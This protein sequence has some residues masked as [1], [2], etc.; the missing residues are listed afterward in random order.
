M[1][2]IL[3]LLALSITTTT[4]AADLTMSIHSTVTMKKVAKD[5]YEKINEVSVTKRTLL[6]FG[7]PKRKNFERV[8]ADRMTYSLDQNLLKIQ[9]EKEGVDIDM[10]VTVDR[11]LFGKLKSFTISGKKLEKVYNDSLARKGIL[12][13]RDLDLKSNERKSLVVGNQVCTVDKDSSSLLTCEQETTLNVTNN[14]A[15]LTALLFIFEV[16]I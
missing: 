14:G 4:F 7:E 11:N 1:K 15:V 5:V 3:A 6:S 16:E 2:T 10:S 12:S 9:D 13:L 8:N